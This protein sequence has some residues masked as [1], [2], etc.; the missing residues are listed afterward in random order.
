MSITTTR[1][2][3]VLA[4]LVALIDNVNAESLTNFPATVHRCVWAT[5][6]LRKAGDGSTPSSCSNCDP[7]IPTCNPGCQDLIDTVYHACDQIELPDGYYYDPINELSGVWEDNLVQ[8]KINVE[9]CGCNAA[10]KGTPI[11]LMLVFMATMV[12]ALMMAF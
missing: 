1:F 9:R 3:L 10:F 7:A 5:N 8:Y 4:V 6:K 2:A 12:A 11:S